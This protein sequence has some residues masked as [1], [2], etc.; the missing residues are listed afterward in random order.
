MLQEQTVTTVSSGNNNTVKAKG[1]VIAI[2]Q[3]ID[4]QKIMEQFGLM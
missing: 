3:L 2:G 1:D 4:K